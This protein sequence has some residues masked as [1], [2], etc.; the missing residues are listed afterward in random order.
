MKT[1]SQFIVV[2]HKAKK[3]G[4]HFDLRFKM[5]K[6]QNWASFAVRKGVPLKPGV[7]VLAVKTHDHSKKE[8]LMTGKIESGYGAGTLKKWDGGSCDI[9]KYTSSNIAIDF[10]GSKVKG[11]YYLIN[12]GVMDKS[13]YKKSQYML[14]KGKIVIEG[15]GMISRIPSCGINDEVEE[16]S[17]EEKGKKLPWSIGKDK[18]NNYG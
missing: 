18:E 13:K 7:R 5:P 3:A 15:T 11:L 12:T 16:D 4:L 14:F 17:G 2:E 8:A 9:L 6:S 10:K 1:K